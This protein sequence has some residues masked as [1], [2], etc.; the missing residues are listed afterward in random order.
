MSRRTSFSRWTSVNF[1]LFD[2]CFIC[3]PYL[4]HL[5]LCFGQKDRKTITLR[6]KGGMQTARMAF[7]EIDMQ[8]NGK[9]RKERIR[10]LITGGSKN[11]I[12]EN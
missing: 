9:V 1:Y 5:C 12:I 8:R 2:N 11:F 3:Q 6:D 7:S 10:R 4:L